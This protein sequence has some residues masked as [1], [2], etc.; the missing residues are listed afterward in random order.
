MPQVGLEFMIPWLHSKYLWLNNFDWISNLVEPV[1]PKG[2]LVAL[3]EWLHN[4]F[5]LKSALALWTPKIYLLHKSHLILL[6]GILCQIPTSPTALPKQVRLQETWMSCPQWTLLWRQARSAHCQVG[7]Q[8][9]VV[10]VL[11][12]PELQCVLCLFTVWI[13]FCSLY[14]LTSS[15]QY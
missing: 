6:P 8:S 10:S 5:L 9:L 15:T 13:R 7:S 1:A 2:I 14:S 3:S 4:S 11:R 12:C